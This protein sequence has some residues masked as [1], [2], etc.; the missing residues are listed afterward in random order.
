VIQLDSLTVNAAG[1]SNGLNLAQGGIDLRTC[2]RSGVTF[3]YAVS[4]NH[5]LR[6]GGSLAVATVEDN[7]NINLNGDV[8]CRVI[9]DTYVLGY[10]RAVDS[11]GY[12][13]IAHDNEKL[14]AVL[15]A[16]PTPKFTAHPPDM[17][18]VGYIFLGLSDRYS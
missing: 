15:S 13:R 12:M 10:I 6:V 14:T 1:R 18:Y 7:L 8:L 4:F 16:I 3:S 17:E 9:R 11:S 5:S 2:S